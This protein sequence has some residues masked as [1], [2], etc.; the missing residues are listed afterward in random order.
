MGALAVAPAEVT[1]F[2]PSGVVCVIL[3]AVKPLH[4][5]SKVELEKID[6]INHKPDNDMSEYRLEAEMN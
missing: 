2:L 4:T 5:A 1:I 3:G 6:H